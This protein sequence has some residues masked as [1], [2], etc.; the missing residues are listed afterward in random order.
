MAF[1]GVHKSITGRKWIGPN[2]EQHRR[3]EAISQITGQKPPVAS[4]LARLAISP[5]SVDT[6]LNPLIKNLL[7]D[8]KQLL[9]VS[10]AAERLIRALDH[11]ERI[12]IFAD[13]DVDGATSGAMLV[14]WY[15]FFNLEP[16]IYVPDRIK[17]GYGPNEQAMKVLSSKHDLII[18]VDCGTMGHEA[19]EAVNEECD[20][21][22]LD[23]HLGSEVDPKCHTIVNPNRQV[24]SGNLSY[25]C[26]AGVVFLSLVEC[27]RK[28][29]N[30][31]KSSP[32]LMDYLDLVA[33][34][35]VADVAP[36]VGA[37]RAFVLQGLKILSKR[38]R[39]GLKVLMDKSAL[40]SSPTSYHLG[41]LLGPKL[42][43]PG[44][45]GPADLALRLLCSTV[46]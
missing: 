38:Q 39:L 12:V 14:S 35:T 23:H 10:K 28:L 31:G 41:Y 24:E 33:L 21:L 40:N 44:R 20:V 18:C 4:V 34:G 29:K 5:E 17:E 16:D 11:R 13:Y 36:L 9:D 30:S 3:A 27:G 25:L 46:A 22:I 6:Y 1:L 2:D 43:A 45:I 26:A 8:P 7:P 15:R 37:N 32:N 19:F 42:N